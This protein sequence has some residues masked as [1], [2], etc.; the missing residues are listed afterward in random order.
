[1]SSVKDILFSK[2]AYLPLLPIPPFLLHIHIGP[3][4]G[5]WP[6]PKISASIGRRPNDAECDDHVWRLAQ[7]K[8]QKILNMPKGAN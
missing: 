8:D 2:S 3:R 5:K 6:A 4:N 7:G 1:M